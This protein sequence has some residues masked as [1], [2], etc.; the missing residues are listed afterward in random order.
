MLFMLSYVAFAES[1]C[2]EC[3]KV[4]ICPDGSLGKTRILAIGGEGNENVP[5]VRFE[6]DL[7]EFKNAIIS[8]KIKNIEYYEVPANLP[9]NAKL[10]RL[11]RLLN[12]YI[13]KN[14]RSCDNTIILFSGHGTESEVELG[15]SKTLTA[16]DFRDMQGAGK[17]VTIINACQSG[18]FAQKIY[19]TSK[20]GNIVI[21]STTGSENCPA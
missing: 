13:L 17:V 14:Q 6:N 7:K 9:G 1:S 10:N 4:S 5:T 2:F 21:A 20:P 3:P 19:S 12:N 8:L 11:N 16:S 18:S 15:G